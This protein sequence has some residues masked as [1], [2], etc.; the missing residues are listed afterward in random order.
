MQDL[1]S[2]AILIATLLGGT[3]AAER[4]HNS[5][6]EASL[7]KAASGVPRLSRFASVLTA[8][9]SSKRK[10]RSHRKSSER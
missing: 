7:T 8:P 9:H 4:I 10:L 3:F 1:I 6:R 5:V 2:A